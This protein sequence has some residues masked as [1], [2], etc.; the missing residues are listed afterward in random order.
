MTAIQDHN[1]CNLRAEHYRVSTPAERLAYVIA[2]HLRVCRRC[3]YYCSR[4]RKP[5]VVKH[6]IG[7]ELLKEVRKEHPRLGLVDVGQETDRVIG[8]W[9]QD[10]L[11]ISVQ[12]P[13]Q[14]AHCFLTIQDMETWITANVL[15]TLQGSISIIAQIASSPTEHEISLVDYALWKEQPYMPPLSHQRLSA[16]DLIAAHM[17]G[18]P[19]CQHARERGQHINVFAHIR[20]CWPSDQQ[21]A[22]DWQDVRDAVAAWSHEHQLCVIDGARQ[23]SILDLIMLAGRLSTQNPPWSIHLESGERPPAISDFFSCL[24]FLT[25]C[26]QPCPYPRYTRE[27]AQAIVLDQFLHLDLGE[28]QPVLHYRLLAARLLDFQTLEQELFKQWND[29]RRGHALDFAFPSPEQSQEWDGKFT[30]LDAQR[31]PLWEE[32]LA[33][34]EQLFHQGNVTSDISALAR[35]LQEQDNDNDPTKD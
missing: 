26:Q 19:F 2:R 33:H 20:E 25:W 13:D 18:C 24:E 34:A 1:P 17:D 9:Q 30:W 27:Q 28:Q 21:G 5:E 35:Q 3:Q 6:L 10:H 14:Q 15:S 7:D 22:F 32:L 4:G 12:C 31:E 23:Y 29:L 8:Q 11:T 16:E